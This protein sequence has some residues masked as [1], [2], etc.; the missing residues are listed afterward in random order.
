M[1]RLASSGRSP[2]PTK[3][4]TAGALQ[5]NNPSEDLF[6][7]QSK[8]RRSVSGALR[9]PSSLQPTIEEDEDEL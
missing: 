9:A 2:S 6:Q 5:L 8:I 1:A 3:R 4:A 7:T